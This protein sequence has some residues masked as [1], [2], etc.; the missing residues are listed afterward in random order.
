MHNILFFLPRGGVVLLLGVF[1]AFSQAQASP[2]PLSFQGAVA[3]TLAHNP[4][5]HQFA[6]KKQ[7]LQGLRLATDMAPALNL[8]IEVANFAGGGEFAGVNSATT[9]VALSSVIELGNRRGARVSV[10][11]AKLGVLGYQ[12]QASTLDV[13]GQLAAIFVSTLEL[14]ALIEL[15]KE[16]QVLAEKTLTIVKDRSQRGGAPEYEAHR[17]AAALAQV[18]LELSALQHQLQRNRIKLA[19]FWGEVAPAWQQVEGDLY[20][21]TAS[22]SFTELYQLALSSPVIHVFASE[23]RL[24]TAQLQLAKAHSKALV[25]WQVGLR[26]FQ[27]EDETAITASLSIPLFSAARNRGAVATAVAA[28]DEVEHE[29]EAAIVRLHS[30]LFDAYSQRQQHL[31]AVEVFQSAIIPKL[32]SALESTRQAYKTG[33]Y[34]YQDW[35]AAQRQLLTAKHRLVQS[36]AA[37]ALSQTVIEQLVAQPLSATAGVYSA[38]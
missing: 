4:Q 29:R 17:A 6:I 21:F 8:D 34:S 10:A 12:R 13:L 3:R 22:A 36:A 15:A 28:R 23:R 32:T 33:R 20:G 27:Q 19:S 7:A 24:K 18:Q 5:L 25:N 1:M 2:G 9:T 14:Q 30:L 38:P 35:S 26:Q 31:K 16:S 37:A 11:D